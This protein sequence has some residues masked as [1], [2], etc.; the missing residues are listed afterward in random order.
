MIKDVTFLHN[1]YGEYDYVD[2]PILVPVCYEGSDH[3][4]IKRFPNNYC[5]NNNHNL[6]SDSNSDEK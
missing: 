6:V 2:K 1:T 5:S 4:D 3:E